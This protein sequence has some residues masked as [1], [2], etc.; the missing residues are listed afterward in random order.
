MIFA[1]KQT[2]SAIFLVASLAAFLL[3]HSVAIGDDEA[4]KPA[5][6]A[7]AKPTAAADDKKAEVKPEDAWKKSQDL[8]AKFNN[9]KATVDDL[10]K[11]FGADPKDIIKNLGLDPDLVKADPKSD[12]GFTFDHKAFE[13]LAPAVQERNK[14]IIQ[15]IASNEPLLAVFNNQSRDANKDKGCLFC[16]IAASPDER[17]FFGVE[18]AKAETPAAVRPA[19]KAAAIR[20]AVEEAAV[21]RVVA[22]V[23]AAEEDKEMKMVEWARCL[24]NK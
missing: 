16:A 8:I 22:E 1:T 18:T 10:R 14:A 12:H 2:K 3:V 20:V 11:A 7:D 9:H 17:K 6:S 19:Q 23:A 15:A 13:K 24:L 21:A 5:A 4:K